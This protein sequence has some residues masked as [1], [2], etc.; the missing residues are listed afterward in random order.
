M[1]TD[2]TRTFSYTFTSPASFQSYADCGLGTGGFH[3]DLGH[4][5]SPKGPAYATAGMNAGVQYLRTMNLAD[6][7]TSMKNTPDGASTLLDNSAV[8]TTS[9][10]SESQTHS[11][12]DFPLLVSGKAGGKFKGDQ[13]IR[14]VGDNT[15]KVL[16]ELYQAYGG[17]AATFGMNEGQVS[18]GVP[19]LRA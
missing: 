14:L 10:T 17:T 13:H 9:C 12:I 1:S 4:R 2:L 16:Y 19:A 6:L 11:P 18:S 15:T 8:Y 5:Q 7:L 3:G